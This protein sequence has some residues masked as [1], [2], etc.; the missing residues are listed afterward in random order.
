MIDELSIKANRAVFA[1]KSKVKLSQIPL[2][3]AI[4]I[5]NAQ[6]TPILLYGSEVWGPYMNIDYAN[7]DN[8]KTERGVQVQFLKQILGCNFQTSNNMIRA[9]TGSRPLI[10]MIIK[11]YISY[12]KSLEFRKYALCYDSSIFENQNTESPNFC[13][14]MEKFTLDIKELPNKSKKEI[15]KTCDGNYDRFWVSKISE[16]TKAASFIMFKTNTVLEPHLALNFNVKHKKA[17][18]RFRLSNHTLMIEKGRH[19]KIEKTERKCYFCKEKI[20]N[21]EH[22]LVNC[23]LYSPQRKILEN[24]CTKN[25]I[26]YKNLIEKERFI[27]IMSNENETIIKAVGKFITDS[28]IITDQIITYFFS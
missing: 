20:E 14:F 8:I 11:R 22:F 24:T 26:R 13:K 21:E 7:W 15:N 5:F 27:F 25:C 4:R 18:S 17:I 10:N 28:F 19:L 2:K 3:L 12:T 9:D 6:V 1:I 16:S 23:P